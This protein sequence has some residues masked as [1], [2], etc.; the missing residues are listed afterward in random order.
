MGESARTA[1][2]IVKSQ[3]ALIEKRGWSEIAREM[4]LSEEEIQHSIDMIMRL[5]PKPGRK[6]YSQ[7]SLAVTPDASIEPDPDSPDKYTI[8]IHDEIIPELRVNSYYRK[9]MRRKDLDE[10]TRFF[11]KE[12]LQRAVN[13]IKAIG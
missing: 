2:E 8:E 5:E 9:L 10:K 1:Y 7:D 6:F 13:F 12:R 3:F 11:L 4:D